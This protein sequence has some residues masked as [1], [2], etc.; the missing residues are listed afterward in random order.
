MLRFIA[1]LTVLAALTACSTS[2]DDDA[3]LA[4]LRDEAVVD[5][6]SA[7]GTVVER[8]TS[9]CEGSARSDG[10]AEVTWAFTSPDPEPVVLEQFE[11]KVTAVGWSAASGSDYGPNVLLFKKG[12]SQL[13][14]HPAA[15]DLPYQVILEAPC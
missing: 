14:L 2:D 1:V 5:A 6:T 9:P 3:T 12:E 4:R 10:W 11:S 13:R 15:P 8:T 7:N